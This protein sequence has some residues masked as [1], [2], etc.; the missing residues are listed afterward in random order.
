MY[1]MWKMTTFVH[2]VK[3]KKQYNLTYLIFVAAK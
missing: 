2:H 3:G 1:N